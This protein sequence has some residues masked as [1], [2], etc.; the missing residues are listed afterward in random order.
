MGSRVLLV[1]A[2][3]VVAGAVACDS[4]PDAESGGDPCVRT[5]ER[6]SQVAEIGE[7]VELLD[8]A[9]VACRSFTAYD[10]QLGRYPG[11]IGYD[12]LTY[13]TN[14]CAALAD[15]ELVSESAVCTGVVIPTTTIEG[16]PELEYVGQTLDGREV[17]IGPD[18]TEFVEGNPVAIVAIV[19]I[20]AEDG[21]PGVEIELTNWLARINDPIIGDQAS[22]YAQHAENVLAF[23]GCGTATTEP[24]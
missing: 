4:D 15:D 3:I 7:Q 13:V 23:M 19:D 9:L 22:V 2:G 11:I 8:A 10:A 21:C 17:T 14:R 6:A 24:G 18:D 20:A 12:S 1:L 16:S 5:I